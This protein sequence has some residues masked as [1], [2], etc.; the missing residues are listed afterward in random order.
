M[1][2]AEDANPRRHPHGQLQWGAV[3]AR[4]AR[5]DRGAGP[6]RLVAAC[7]RRRV[8]RPDPR[9]RGGVCPR[10]SGPAHRLAKGA[11]K[12][13][14]R[15]LPVAAS[16]PSNP[17]GPF[18]LCRSGRCLAARQA[19]PGGRDACAPRGHPGA[20]RKPHMDRGGRPD[21]PRTVPPAA[22]RARVSQ[23][24]CAKPG[25][26]QHDG[27]ERPRTPDRADGRAGRG[28]GLPRLVAIS[29]GLR[30]G[31]QGRLRQGSDASLPPARR[32]PDRREP[33][34]S[35]APAATFRPF[36]WPLR[37]VE[38]R[39]C[40]R[41]AAGRAPSD[42]GK[43]R[44]PGRVHPAAREPR[45]CRPARSSRGGALPAKPR[46]GPF[47]CRRRDDGAGLTTSRWIYRP[48]DPSGPRR[49]G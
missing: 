33:V 45:P 47:A 7:L 38:P 49:F 41:T 11:C 9:D 36:P 30:C 8:A 32:Q 16:R 4:P 34:V 3:P 6:R 37:G 46:R 12:G 24:A 27:P 2:D 1:T 23:R 22:T 39:Q 48:E 13:Q 25:G 19:D 40:Q 18:R 26:R 31:R 21:D 10:P 20:L 43:P 15:E 29:T 5:F 28:G 35:R 17:G 14:H 42:A 44:L